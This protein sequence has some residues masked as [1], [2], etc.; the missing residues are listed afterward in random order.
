MPPRAR[1]EVVRDAH[2]GITV[3][4]PYRWLE[5]R[6]S[7]EPRAWVEAQGAY[8]CAYLD[9]LPD[10]QA[11]FAR[12]AEL[13]RTIPALTDF[14]MAAG[15]TFYL[16][17]DPGQDIPRLVARD[18]PDSPE[19]TVFD[20]TSSSADVHSSI[21]WYNPSR[22][23]RLVA[24]GISE[25]G[26]EDSVLH[27][28]E[29]DT[30]KLVSHPITR[31][32]YGGVTWL[33][34]DSSF[35]YHRWAQLPEGAPE[36]DRYRD[37]R[38]YLHH[39]G[40]DPE[41]DAPVFG[42]GINTSVELS[43]DDFPFIV[44]SPRSGWM[45]GFVMHGVQPEYT[46]YAAPLATLPDPP[47]IPWVKV[48]D[49]EDKVSGPPAPDLGSG[50]LVLD[51]D[52]LFLRTFRDAPRFKIIGLDLMQPDMAQARTIVP[53]G[54][55]VLQGFQQAGAYL[56][57]ED[58]DAGL[59]RMRRLHASSGQIDSVPVPIEGSISAWATDS[60]S[61]EVV[62]QMESWIVAP[63]VYNFQAAAP[64]LQ[65]TG[66]TPPCPIDFSRVEAR[67]TTYPAHDGTAVPISIIGP[68]GLN[69]DGRNPTIVTGYGSYGI[70]LN[71][72]FRPELMAWYERGGLWAVAHIRGGGERGQEWHEAGHKLNK[73]NTIEDFIAAAEYL[74]AEGYTSPGYLAGRG[75]SAGGIP[76]G[77][78]LVRRP[79]LWRV[80][81][82][83]VAVTNFFRMEFS[84]NGP[85]NIP[86][87]GTVATA[88]GSKAL[89]IIDSYTK[90]CNGVAYPA[91]L[92]TTGLNDPRVVVW[93]ATKLAARLQAATSSS[94]PILLRVEQQGGHGFGSTQRQLDEE[95]ADVLA[96][97]L[98]QCG[99]TGT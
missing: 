2:F 38:T 70:S 73:G 86:E 34:D 55:S 7:E 63:S 99:G 39:L 46:M 78:A 91:V 84:E 3:E 80:M 13:S 92:I 49:V 72:V 77:G 82:M 89:Q 74:I 93:Q 5:D 44:L 26:S 15:R 23:G 10:R 18:A 25:G 60:S 57:I 97:V 56:I 69:Q 9:A 41:Q 6:R 12:I 51:G 90:I 48:V 24:F 11:L 81:L 87:F 14:R 21:D 76:T 98:Q 47:S 42:N 36:T 62:L 20:P 35:L 28:V 65:D 43:R 31:T 29:V 33:P 40:D 61:G 45:V 54:D 37:S 59:S 94:R 17:R 16:R 71:P 88:E 53:Q 50:T 68:R 58:L 75:G 66:W 22:D 64:R 52:T 8:A 32:Q 79:E 4:D 83:H 85:P 30:A 96:F 27:V 19:R 95:L 67:E 1:V